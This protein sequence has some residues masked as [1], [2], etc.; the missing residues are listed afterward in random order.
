M[1]QILLVDD[2]PQIL[3]MLRTSLE[4]AGYEIATAGNGLEALQR[5]ELSKPDLLITDL[6]MPEMNG[7]ELTEAIREISEV[8]I[9]VLSVRSTD[10]MKIQALDKGADDYLTKPFSMSELMARVRAHL[11]RS[12]KIADMG[13]ISAGD[14]TVDEAAHTVMVRGTPV[15]LTPKEFV[16]LLA[17]ARKPERVLS[18]NVLLRQVWGYASG[19]QAENLRVLVASLRKK[20]EPAGG[21]H[22]IESEPGIGYRFHP[23]GNIAQD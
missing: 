15:H 7:L 10:M 12:M 23:G 17:F 2:E 16:L 18:H 5:F 3:R 21:P 1:S 9:I 6:A 4:S 14:F 8:P 11:R 19:H 22:Y 13:G 20:V